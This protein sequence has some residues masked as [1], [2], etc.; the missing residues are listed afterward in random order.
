MKDVLGKWHY[1]R[2]NGLEGDFP[3]NL[4]EIY[5]R[6]KVLKITTLETPI[7]LNWIYPLRAS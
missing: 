5:K 7:F 1:K 2:G 4:I 6:C 3:L